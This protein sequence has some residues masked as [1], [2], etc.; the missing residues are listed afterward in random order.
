MA[1]FIFI[2][3]SFSSISNCKADKNHGLQ[4]RGG[5]GPRRGFASGE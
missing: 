1:R 2:Y 3:L 5:S 4:M